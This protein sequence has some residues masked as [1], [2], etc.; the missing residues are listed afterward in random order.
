MKVEW[1]DFEQRVREFAKYIWGHEC[2]PVHI[3]GVDIDGGIIM[4]TD[5]HVFIEMTERRE[6]AKVREDVVKLQVAKAALLQ[7]N[8]AFARCFCV[9]NGSVTKAM[10]EAGAPHQIKVLSF[11]NYTKIFFDF[12]SYKTSREMAAFGSAVNPLTGKKDDSPYVPVSYMIDGTSRSVIFTDI[13]KLL[14]DGKRIVLLGEYGSGKSRCVLEVFKDMASRA[15]GGHSYP[16]AIDLRE[17]WGVKR[18]PELIRRHLEDL[19]ADNLQM[20]AIR[21]LNSGYLCL[22]LDGFDELGSQAWSN[23]SEKLRVIRAKSLE[24]VRDLIRKTT[25][26]VFVCGREHYFNNSSEMYDALG[27]EADATILLRCRTEFT[28]QETTEFFKRLQ[29]E[30]EIPSWLPRRPLICQTIADLSAD[31]L[32]EMFGVGDNEIEFW[33]HFIKVLCE[34]EALI[35]LMNPLIFR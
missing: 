29:T 6:L 2:T 5:L 11:D 30:I 23:D 3:G 13:V 27:L 4:D 20:S 18:G 14:S 7:Q 10:V 16:M 8:G 24:G 22:L 26:G 21:A 12:G 32:D 17:Q 19:G 15:I 25:G 35:H 31:E 33:D 1:A 34:R 9:V 28:E